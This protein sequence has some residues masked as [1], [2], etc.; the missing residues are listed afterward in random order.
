MKLRDVVVRYCLIDLRCGDCHTHTA[1]DPT[2]FLARRGDIELNDL[3]HD[4]VCPACGSA[5]IRLETV[6]P[7]Q[8]TIDA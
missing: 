4:M 5:E 8:S 1:L 7:V 3:A 2:F 6:S